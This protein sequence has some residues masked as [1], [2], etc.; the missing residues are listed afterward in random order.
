MANRVMVELR[1][2]FIIRRS[3]AG[4][5]HSSIKRPASPRIVTHE[6]KQMTSRTPMP[7]DE[8]QPRYVLMKV[9]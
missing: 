9:S 7:Q 2:S 3:Y 5:C 4:V 8:L 6:S 1:W